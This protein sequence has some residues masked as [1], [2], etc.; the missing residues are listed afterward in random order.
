MLM[1]A[2]LMG[3]MVSHS[4][5]NLHFPEGQGYKILGLAIAFCVYDFCTL[6]K[7]NLDIS[8]L[9]DVLLFWRLLLF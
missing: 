3:E 9:S 8:C 4:N 2:I 6:R 5:F 1:V 7:Q